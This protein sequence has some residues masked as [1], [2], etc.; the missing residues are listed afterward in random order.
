MKYLGRERFRKLI[1][2]KYENIT[3]SYWGAKIRKINVYGL[4]LIFWN[5]NKALQRKM[6]MQYRLSNAEIPLAY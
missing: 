6:E 4:L 2:R 3:Q 1:K 5:K